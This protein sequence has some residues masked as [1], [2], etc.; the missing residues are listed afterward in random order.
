MPAARAAALR[1]PPC[2]REQDRARRARGSVSMAATGS[3]LH[4]R[5]DVGGVDAAR[6]RGGVGRAAQ[7]VAQLA[8]V[9]R[10]VVGGE[11]REGG[12]RELA[13]PDLRRE[14]AGAGSRAMAPMSPRRSRSG[15]TW[16]TKHSSRWKR[17]RRKSPAVT[18]CSSGACVAAT[19]RTSAFWPLPGGADAPH[20]VAVER[21]QELGLRVEREVADLVEEEGAAVGLGEGAEPLRVG[22]GEGSALVAE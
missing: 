4:G 10:P 11:A 20:L 22:A 18:R 17:S 16:R 8:H 5:D 14:L 2:S 13:G 19:T 9:A 7:H 6:A 3:R 1:L 12:G 21:A 15:G